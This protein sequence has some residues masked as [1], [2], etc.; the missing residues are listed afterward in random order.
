MT[1]AFSP[2]APEQASCQIIS[3]EMEDFLLVLLDFISKVGMEALVLHAH[4]NGHAQ[5]A[6]SSSSSSAAGSS[7]DGSA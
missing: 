5:S 1:H 7:A 4:I 6:S 2:R 3:K